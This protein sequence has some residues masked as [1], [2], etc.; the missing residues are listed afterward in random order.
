M[1]ILYLHGLDATPS[2]DKVEMLEAFGNEVVAPTLNYRSGP[3]FEELLA[4]AKRERIDCIVGS[5]MGG[6]VARHL[7]DA[8]LVPCLLI[9]PALN[10][11]NADELQPLKESAKQTERRKMVVVGKDDGPARRVACY[12]WRAKNPDFL[13]HLLQGVGHQAGVDVVRRMF[14]RFLEAYFPEKLARYAD[15]MR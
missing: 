2:R 9:N 5:S 6:H 4:T 1:K 3:V 14:V 11:A 8:L 7:A 10:S 12:R 15:L 13:L